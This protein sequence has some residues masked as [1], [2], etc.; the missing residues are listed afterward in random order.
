M[1]YFFSVK[2]YK[3]LWI[4]LYTPKQWVQIMTGFNI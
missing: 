3:G 2:E 1:V 4:H